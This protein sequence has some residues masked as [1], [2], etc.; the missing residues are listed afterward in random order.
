[1]WARVSEMMLGFWLCISPFVF[2]GTASVDRFVALDL[3]TGAAVVV[4]SLASFWRRA[5]LAHLATAA[6]ALWLGLQAYFTWERPGPPAA[7][8]EIIVAML[9]LILAI[10]PNDA[11]DPPRPWRRRG[12]APPLR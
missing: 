12:D 5:R 10:I 4:L 3:A 9:L 1:M 8:N 2:R 11:S 7:Q 6:L